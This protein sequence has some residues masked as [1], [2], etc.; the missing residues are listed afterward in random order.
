MSANKTPK[1][2]AA[3]RETMHKVEQT[4]GVKPDDPAF[5]ELKKIL[6]RRVAHERET[7]AEEISRHRAKS[8]LLTDTSFVKGQKTQCPPKCLDPNKNLSPAFCR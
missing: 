6:R 4:S 5:V 7:F 8:P 2:I 3:L 1:L